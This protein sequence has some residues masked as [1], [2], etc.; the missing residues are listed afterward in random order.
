LN[1]RFLETR[2]SGVGRIFAFSIG[3]QTAIDVKVFSGAVA[4]A[5]EEIP[6]SN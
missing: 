5:L 4:L 1:E 2:A 6:P 3:E